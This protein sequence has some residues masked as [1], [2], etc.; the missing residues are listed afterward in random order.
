MKT[1]NEKTLDKKL[2]TESEKMGWWCLKMVW[3]SFTGAPDR[4]LLGSHARIVFAEIK[5]PGKKPTARQLWVHGK[6]RAFGFEVWLVD[7][8]EVLNKLLDRLNWHYLTF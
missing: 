7:S 4:L 6:L 1:I 5:S 3:S 2:K 8:E